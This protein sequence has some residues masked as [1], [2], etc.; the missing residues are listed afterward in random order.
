MKPLSAEDGRRFQNASGELTLSPPGSP[1]EPC[2]EAVAAALPER[3]GA[4]QG[5]IYQ[6]FS[7]EGV[8]PRPE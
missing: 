1:A 6:G 5:I 8:G 7:D 4:G 3:P 2:S